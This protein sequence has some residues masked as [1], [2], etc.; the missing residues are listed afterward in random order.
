MW[1]GKIILKGQ[2]K[3]PHVE[4]PKTK[5]KDRLGAYSTVPIKIT[6]WRNEPLVRRKFVKCQETE[7]KV[8]FAQLLE[9]LSSVPQYQNTSPERNKSV[10]YLSLKNSKRTSKCQNIVELWT[11][12]W[13]FFLKKSFTMPKK[14]WKG[15]TSGIFQHPFCRKT[16]R[17]FVDN[18]FREKESHDAEKLRGSS[19]SLARY[20]MLRGEKKEKP[21]WF[22]SSLGQQ[23]QYKIL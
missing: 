6:H 23:E 1:I 21:L 4:K 5:T 9:K 17:P 19:F 11:L 10:L 7:K 18:F 2:S 14:N 8:I 16:P 20:C 22:S 12:W 13:N 3:T 15:G